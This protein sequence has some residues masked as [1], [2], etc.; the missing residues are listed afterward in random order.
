MNNPERI[1][2]LLVEANPVPEPETLALRDRSLM[3]APEITVVEDRRLAAAADTDDE[4]PP[5]QFRLLAVAAS[6]VLVVGLG[7][8]LLTYSSS[9]QP[10]VAEELLP[11]I[12]PSIG[13]SEVAPSIGESEVAPSIGEPAVGSL[14]WVW[15]S[16]LDNQ[17]VGIP[18][19]QI[20][21]ESAG[22]N[23][24]GGGGPGSPPGRETEV[25]LPAGSVSIVTGLHVVPAVVV[26]NDLGITDIGNPFGEDAWVCTVSAN[27]T[28]ALA[29]GSS[30]WWTNDG[31]VWHR[32]EMF[33]ELGGTNIDGSDLVWAG[34]G[35]LGYVVLGRARVEPGDES[36]IDR[37]GWH[38]A[39]LETWHEIPPDGATYTSWGWFGPQVIDITDQ[40]IIILMQ[41]GG[42]VGRP[43]RGAGS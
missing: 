26:S 39:D 33:N 1:Y 7:A 14:E 38:S 18:P 34:A 28:T 40:Q 16:E 42:L 6:L 13:E 3:D 22:P 2:A 10:G 32:V 43:T 23:C 29:V 41:E 31:V 27:D 4:R 17:S 19:G 30:V 15:D 20:N 21:F 8:V 37:R 11:P 5:H 12:A 25:E 24:W 36:G 9:P 35:P